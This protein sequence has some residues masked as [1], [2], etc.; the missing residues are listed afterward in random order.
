MIRIISEEHM[1]KEELDILLWLLDSGLDFYHFRKQ[2][3]QQSDLI[4]FLNQIPQAY[5]SKIVLHHPISLPGFLRHHNAKQRGLN[6]ANIHSCSVH[7]KTELTTYINQYQFVFWSPV[8]DSISKDGYLKNENIQLSDLASEQKS[9]LIAL[10]GI[11][12]NKFKLAS[13]M[14]F[15]HIALKGWFWNRKETYK[16]AWI[17]IQTTWQELEKKY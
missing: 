12:P 9:K 8:F 15:S 10:G 14:G 2:D 13:N 4:A 16:E 6:S 3:V 7:S 11:E 1:H 5:R 17:K